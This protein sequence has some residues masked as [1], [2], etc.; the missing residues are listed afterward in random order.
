MLGFA[1][2]ND[3]TTNHKLIE[4]EAMCKTCFEFGALESL[5]NSPCPKSL[6]FD[7][8]DK[9]EKSVSEPLPGPPCVNEKSVSVPPL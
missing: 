9:N 6:S 4:T 7:T 3:K 2:C 5:K 8:N 1:Y